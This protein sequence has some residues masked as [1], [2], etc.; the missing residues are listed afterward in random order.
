MI[1]QESFN[2]LAKGYTFI[3]IERTRAETGNRQ[4]KGYELYEW[5]G[6]VFFRDYDT[7]FMIRVLN[8]THCNC[9][10]TFK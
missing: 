5:G 10:F 3:E 1:T 9:T 4:K 7:T 2:E 6:N 8:N